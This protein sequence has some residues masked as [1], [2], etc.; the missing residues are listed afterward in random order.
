[1]PGLQ[2]Q[3][4]PPPPALGQQAGQLGAGDAGLPHWHSAGGRLVQDEDIPVVNPESRVQLLD[5]GVPQGL[6]QGVLGGEPDSAAPHTTVA[7]PSYKNILV[8]GKP[9]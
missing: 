2:A 8:Q 6:H 7:Q 1:M 4:L 5:Q 3:L 9:K